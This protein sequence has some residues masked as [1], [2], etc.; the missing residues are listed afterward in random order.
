MSGPPFPSFSPGDRGGP[1]DDQARQIR[2]LEALYGLGLELV[3]NLEPRRVLERA[4]VLAIQLVGA[5]SGG[6]YLKRP[7]A[8]HELMAG[9]GL[10]AT[11]VGSTLPP[12]RGV[13]GWVLGH[14]QAILVNDY[15]A[16]PGHV[17]QLE[18]RP[19][20]SLMG[21]P[22]RDAEGVVGALMI[23]HESKI[24]AFHEDD[25]RLLER[26][27]ALAAV[28]LQNARLYEAERRRA[29]DEQLR[30]TVSN[31]IVRLRGVHELC[32]AVTHELG[33]V[34]GYNHVMIYLLRD[35]ALHL[36]SQVGYA[37]TPLTVSVQQGVMG[38]TVRLAQPILVKDAR[39]E[40]DFLYFAPNL[41]SAVSVPLLGRDGVLGML[42]VESETQ[43]DERDLAMLSSLA[44]PVAMALENARLHESLVQ[45][46]LE[47]E[48]VAFLDVLTGLPNRRA[49]A[50]DARQALAET[51]TCSLVA[52]DLMGF[53]AINDQF[54][55]DAGD[56][57]LRRIAQVFLTNGA[58]AFRVGGDE[59]ML[60]VPSDRNRALETVK[61]LIAAVVE[62][63][64][65]SGL[66]VGLNAGV[67]EAPTDAT[68]LDR[69]QNLA[70]TRMYAAKRVGRPVLE[71][72]ELE[73][74]PVPRRRAGER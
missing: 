60:I 39:Q 53:K 44:A 2:Q 51:A 41:R 55:H 57:A 36:E 18:N 19:N 25:L 21:A 26:F 32:Q 29:R 45:A 63:E 74:P 4:L 58:L 61:S 68:D 13:S 11:R 49:F 72:G 30:A 64:F 37:N 6:V 35:E 23:G 20:R 15:L 48:R 52:M 46:K 3:A 40:P 38:R 9:V 67:A 71:F 27:A 43:L 5:D 66:R 54:G 1:P 16:W 73:H 17:E 50:R 56:D 7:D 8:T 47:A 70:D 69:L 33:G 34:L 22:L 62:L 24:N 31:A 10:A 42:A 12:G 28:A 59:F 65:G 14:N